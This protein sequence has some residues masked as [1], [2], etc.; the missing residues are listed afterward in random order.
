[1]ID[2]SGNSVLILGS[3]HDVAA[4]VVAS[5]QNLGAKVIIGSDTPKPDTAGISYI[6]TTLDDLLLLADQL[7]AC[8]FD[9]VIISPGWFEQRPF[10]DMTAENIDSAFTTNFE[11][12]TYAAQAAAK[13]LITR[14]QSGSI[15]FI[16][17][18]A[19]LMPMVHSNL[20]GSSLAAIHVVARMAAVDLA[21]YNIRSNVIAVGWVDDAWSKEMLSETGFMHTPA[22]IPLG[23]AGSISSVGDA[24]CFLA[25]P[26]SHYITGAILPVDG[27]FM[28]TKSASKSPI[29]DK[30]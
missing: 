12:A 30:S 22:D 2:L 4:G 7:A 26:L 20:V 16:S 3:Q 11:H 27:G 8:A 15:I 17:S 24:C 29:R 28:L 5:F 1:M 21:P 6:K 19:G 23:N 18:V 14:E 10:L 9:T 25:S 13:S